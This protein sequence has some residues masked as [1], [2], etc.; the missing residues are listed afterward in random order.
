MAYL[1]FVVK[2]NAR[3]RR[4]HI[5]ESDQLAVLALKIGGDSGVE[6]NASTL[7]TADNSV[8][9]TN[10]TIDG[11]SNTI[12]NIQGSSLSDD[13]KETVLSYRR[14]AVWDQVNTFS[15]NGGSDNVT[16]DVEG[17]AGTDTVTTSA[18]AKGILTTGSGSGG[19]G[20]ENYTVQ[21]RA[22]ASGDPVADGEE[23][24]V[25][26]QL[27]HANGAIANGSITTLT[28]SATVTGTST[29]FLTDFE[30]GDGLYDSAGNFIGYVQSVDSDTQ[31]TL[32]ANAAVA[33]TGDTNYI[34]H[35]YTLTYYQRDGGAYTFASATNVD[36]LF[37]E[38]FDY[39][40]R[41][42]RADLYGT[43]FVDPISMPATH[44]HDASEI[45][46]GT[47][48]T[49]RFSAYDDLVAESKIG[50]ASDQVAAGDH[51]HAFSEIT[52]TLSTDQFSAYDDLV[53]ESKIGTASDQ[54]AAGDHNHAF[55]EIT[56][57]LSTD[58][59]S[60]YDDLVAESKIG[61]ASDQVA[62]GDHNHAFSE[63]TGTLSTDQF[64]AY[65]D[66]VAESKIGTASDQV[67]AG[68]HAHAF[69]EITGTL[70]T[71]QFSA[72]DDLVAES[73]IGTASDQVAAGDHGHAF[74]EI[75]GTLS[76]DQ[77]SAYDDLVAESKIGTASDQVAA[78]DHTH[79]EFTSNLREYTATESIAAGK[80]CYISAAGQVSL[81]DKD[82]SNIHLQRLVVASEEVLSG[83]AGDFYFAPAT[84]IPHLSGLSS[85]VLGEVYL[86]DGGDVTQDISAITTGVRM[87]LGYGYNA[88]SWEFMQPIYLE[89][90]V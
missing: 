5:P 82:T 72:Y 1:K 21:I 34:R 48:S 54:V 10:K 80:V 19:A 64:S 27:T 46:S 9:L 68:D 71:D 89:H 2:T 77:F 57:T 44:T 39:N 18:A 8:V 60:A 67:A 76:T 14:M 17:V 3:D 78:G 79:A 90:V 69:S 38:V 59:F 6:I 41:P 55:S 25:Y 75:T 37:A 81:A 51:N 33:V 16:A 85:V 15:A 24:T 20:I 86:G 45:T 61:T 58:Q 63:I 36:F 43:G 65:D 7:V 26:G 40:D 84:V 28:S 87:L 52:G 56:G 83:V 73:K 70:S 4:E 66:L 49:D 62:A 13:A 31:I 29:T 22:S 47:L 35:R 53:A 74:S 42:W 12:T 11:L 32:T 50:T 23:G 30:A 88:A